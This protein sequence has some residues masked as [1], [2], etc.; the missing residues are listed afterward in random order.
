MLN[1]AVTSPPLLLRL[2][3]LPAGLPSTKNCTLPLGVPVAGATALTV[4]VKLTLC[5]VTDGL[6]EELR[7]I[8]LPA[9]PTAC[10]SMLAVLP[11]KLLSP[12]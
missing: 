4:A 12:L 10:V 8:V 11:E 3:G 7:A 5:P 6:A 1:E 9:L 2:T